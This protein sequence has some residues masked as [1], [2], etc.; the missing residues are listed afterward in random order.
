MRNRR[1]KGDG[2]IRGEAERRLDLI[3]QMWLQEEAEEH[4]EQ[5][6]SQRKLN[7]FMNSVGQNII[8]KPNYK[9]NKENNNE[10]GKCGSTK[11][12]IAH[13]GKINKKLKISVI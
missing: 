11:A 9:Q 8:Q 4:V 1:E 10:L 7:P 3:L 13:C 12:Y 6:H 5:Y 2:R